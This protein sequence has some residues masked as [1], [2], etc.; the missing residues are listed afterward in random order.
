MKNEVKSLYYIG[1]NKLLKRISKLL[2]EEKKNNNINFALNSTESSIDTSF[3]LLTTERFFFTDRTLS[4][5]I[6]FRLLP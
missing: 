1:K 6:E 5:V 2:E 4:K 3:Y